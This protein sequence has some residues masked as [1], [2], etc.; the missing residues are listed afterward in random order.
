M[1][2]VVILVSLSVLLVQAHRALASTPAQGGSSSGAV[3]FTIQSIGGEPAHELKS[4]SLAELAS[5]KPAQGSTKKLHSSSEKDPKVGSTVEWK[6]SLLSDWVDE[7]LSTLSPKSRAEV[8]QLILSGSEGRKV[9]MPRAL[10]VKYPVLLAFQRSGKDLGPDAPQV[11]LPWTS[12]SKMTQE[13]LPLEMLFLSGVK[14]VEFANSKERFQAFRLKRRTDPSAIKG[15]KIFLSNCVSCHAQE[16]G[17]ALAAIQAEGASQKLQNEG[18]PK[19]PYGPH[20]GESDRR[21]MANY[22]TALRAEVGET[23]AK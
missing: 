23:T 19:V 16:Q 1:I 8:D 5:G 11:I 9:F 14:T 22:L 17:R 10:L 2:S 21:M 13:G 12:H 6:G 4:W 20:L 15:E 7:A 3:Q 18:H